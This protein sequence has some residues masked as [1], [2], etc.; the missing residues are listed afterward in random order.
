MVDFKVSEN[1]GRIQFDHFTPTIKDQGIK[2]HSRLIASIKD[3]LAKHGIGAGTIDLSDTN[4]YH[5]KANKKSAINWINKYDESFKEV[6]S[7]EKNTEKA[8]EMIVKKIDTIVQSL[9]GKSD[10]E[11]EKEVQKGNPEAMFLLGDRKKT[12]DPAESYALILAAAKNKYPPAQV[13]CGV[14]ALDGYKV[15]NKEIAPKSLQD[16]IHWFLVAAKSHQEPMKAPSHILL[17]QTQLALYFDPDIPHDNPEIPSLPR[18]H[19]EASYWYIHAYKNGS[20]Q[21]EILRGLAHYY[22]EGKG[23]IKK[24]SGAAD[25]IESEMQNPQRSIFRRQP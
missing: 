13:R 14:Y 3:W 10:E 15:G 12:K 20:Q 4:K 25:L 8:N 6:L 16:A 1:E 11:L 17:A 24:D 23:L 5:W 7:K 22:R 19:E 18:S 9:I 21:N 2:V